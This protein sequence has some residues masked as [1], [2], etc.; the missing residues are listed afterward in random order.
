MFTSVPK[1]KEVAQRMLKEE[2]ASFATN[3]DDIE[4]MEGLQ[5]D[6][7]LSDSIPA[8]FSGIT[9]QSQGLFIRK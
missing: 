7:E 8:A 5:I 4:C 1:Q 9:S 2:D 3:E 6:I